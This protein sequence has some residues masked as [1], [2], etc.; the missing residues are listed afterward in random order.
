V[1]FAS[2]QLEDAY[3][4]S[5]DL[6]ALETGRVSPVT[7]ENLF[8]VDLPAGEGIKT[9]SLGAVDVHVVT[10]LEGLATLAVAPEDITLS[11]TPQPSSARNQLSGRV[12]R[13]DD[14][15]RGQL[16]VTVDA[17]V[18]LT[19][20]VTPAALAELDMTVGTNAVAT[21]KATAVRVF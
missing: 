16:N 7:P 15:R 6:M 13:I 12:I 3:R 9:V 18:E 11:R 19:A 8:R 17:G 10:D 14:S 5:D 20:R 4:W 1:C 21:F 2:H